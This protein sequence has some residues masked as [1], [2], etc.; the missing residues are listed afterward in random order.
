MV[1]SEAAYVESYNAGCALLNKRKPKQAKKAFLDA[2]EKY[3]QKEVSRKKGSYSSRTPFIL[4]PM[5][6]SRVKRL[7]W[8]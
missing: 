3:N 7:I 4:H 8:S 5:R 2:L 6:G 1:K